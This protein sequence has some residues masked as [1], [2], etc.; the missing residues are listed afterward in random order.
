MSTLGWPAPTAGKRGAPSMKPMRHLKPIVLL[1]G[2]L[3][4]PGCQTD[5]STKSNRSPQIVLNGVRAGSVKPQIINAVLDL[6]MVLKSETPSEVTFERPWEI[7]AGS[8]ALA[9]L[10]SA[11]GSSVVER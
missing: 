10:P 3:V 4:L 1:F 7:T 2:V 6:G 5:T 9:A 11:D 8:G